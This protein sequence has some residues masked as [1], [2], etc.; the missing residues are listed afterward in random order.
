DRRMM[1]T[2][3]AAGFL[4]S[5]RRRDVR[6][7]VPA[8]VT[9][10]L[11]LQVGCQPRSTPATPRRGEGLLI[12][13]EFLLPWICDRQERIDQDSGCLQRGTRLVRVYS[14]TR[15]RTAERAKSGNESRTISIAVL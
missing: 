2:S 6:K 12:E 13:P 1:W 14:S 10:V 7:G 3:L 11:R 5:A 15:V 4:G 8:A 9:R